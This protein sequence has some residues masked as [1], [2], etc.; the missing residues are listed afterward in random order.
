VHL[1]QQDAPISFALLVIELAMSLAQAQSLPPNSI[2]RRII[3]EFALAAH[4]IT[5]NNEESIQE[6]IGIYEMMGDRV[7]S[8]FDL[9]AAESYT[10]MQTQIV[11]SRKGI[12]VGN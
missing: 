12:P 7:N 11:S 1:E 10:E 6:L 4:T 5:A 3:A 2:S 9:L 8:Y